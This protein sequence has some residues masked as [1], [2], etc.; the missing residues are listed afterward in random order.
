MKN[1]K[2]ITVFAPLNNAFTKDVVDVYTSLSSEQ[3]TDLLL[4]HVV[5]NDSIP[6]PLKDGDVIKTLGSLKIKVNIDR[7][8]KKIL[9]KNIN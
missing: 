4:S 3:K 6:S 7:R 5:S 8:N 2:N 9:F 1:A